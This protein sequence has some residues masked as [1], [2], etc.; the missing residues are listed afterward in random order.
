V[1]RVARVVSAAPLI[2][3]LAIIAAAAIKLG[4]ADALVFSATREISHWSRVAP[5]QA[6]ETRVLDDLQQAISGVEGDPTA[7]EMLGL[8][9]A[10][11]LGDPERQKQA[12]AEFTRALE[13]RP[14]SP[15]TWIHIAET[16]YRVGDTGPRFEMALGKSVELGAADPEIQNLVAFLGLAV[17]D[18]LGPATRAAVDRMIQA[19]WRR[20]PAEMMRISTRRGRLDVTCRLTQGMSARVDP[21]V[22]QRCQGT[23]EKS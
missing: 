12:F 4:T 15:Y 10:R 1:E 6:A 11:H 16:S 20:D 13:L 2:A 23:G 14:T 9:A 21:K 7:H 22:S 19:G 5:D 3:G 8:L 18:E 17:Y